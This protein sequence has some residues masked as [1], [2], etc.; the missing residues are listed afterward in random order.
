MSGRLIS[1]IWEPP[2]HYSMSPCFSSQ[3]DGSTFQPLPA[4]GFIA[5]TAMT[6]LYLNELH[7]PKRIYF[8]ILPGK[9][10]EDC[11]SSIEMVVMP[12]LLYRSTDWYPKQQMYKATI[13]TLIKTLK[14]TTLF[15][16]CI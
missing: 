4:S 11:F 1:P 13:R 5:I 15:I 9:P 14:T 7:I 12:I 10:R 3:M 2:S 6:I 8:D 16:M